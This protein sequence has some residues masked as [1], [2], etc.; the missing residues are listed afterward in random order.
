[1]KKK[2]KD[3]TPQRCCLSCKKAGHPN[4]KHRAQIQ[5]YVY[6]II[7]NIQTPTTLAGIKVYKINSRIFGGESNCILLCLLVLVILIIIILNFCIFLLFLPTNEFFII[8][9][10]VYFSSKCVI[11]QLCDLLVR[12]DVENNIDFNQ[13]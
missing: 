13:C 8:S 9:N 2:I 12:I 10:I 1:M 5:I 11:S 7:I 4:S 6:N 3:A